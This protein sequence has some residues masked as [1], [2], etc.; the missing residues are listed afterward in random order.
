MAILAEPRSVMLRLIRVASQTA[1]PLGHFPFMR[2]MAGSALRGRMG[3]FQMEL[4][5]RRMAGGA[6]REGLQALLL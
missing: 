4:R 1:F 5:A 2:Q 3:G 6:S